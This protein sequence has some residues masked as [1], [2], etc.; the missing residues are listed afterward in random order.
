[1]FL[2]AGAA[3]QDGRVAVFA[4]ASGKVI[5]RTSDLTTSDTNLP[6]ADFEAQV[7][8]ETSLE[9]QGAVLVF[10]DPPNQDYALGYLHLDPDSIRVYLGGK[11]RVEKGERIGTASDT[12]PDPLPVHLHFEVRKRIQLNGVAVYVPVDPYGWQGEGKDPYNA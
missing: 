10:L 2:T 1:D 7:D 3:S 12:S 11:E 8:G 4:A 9:D 6:G 5:T